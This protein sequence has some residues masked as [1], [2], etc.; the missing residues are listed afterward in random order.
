[1]VVFT[2]VIQEFNKGNREPSNLSP[3]LT[4]RWKPWA[5]QDLYWER[6]G[7]GHVRTLGP[8]AFIPSTEGDEIALAEGE[9]QVLIKGAEISEGLGQH[10]RAVSQGSVEGGRD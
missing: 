10:E 7:S 9:L 5:S 6:R 1:L 4:Y 8:A 2:I 3:E